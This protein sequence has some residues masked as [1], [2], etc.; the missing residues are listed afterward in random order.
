M[1][2][3]ARRDPQRGLPAATRGRALRATDVAS[4]RLHDTDV[5]VRRDGGVYAR[6]LRWLGRADLRDPSVSRFD[7]SGSGFEARF[8]GTGLTLT[9]G[10][11]EDGLVLLAEVDG[12]ASLLRLDR[13]VRDYLLAGGLAQAEHTLRLTRETEAQMGLTALYGVHVQEG[14]LRDPPAA[15]VRLVEVVGDSVSAGY[16]DLC[17]D[18]DAHFGFDTESHAASYGALAARALGADVS[19]LAISGHGLYRNLDASSDALLPEVYDRA[20]LGQPRPSWRP[21]RS[22]D[23]VVITLGANDLGAAA[24]DPSL[25]MA[26]AYLAFVAA[27]RAHHPGALIVC[28]ANPMELGEASEQARLVG[29][30]GRVVA[31]RRAAGDERVVPLVF[32]LLT[33][34]ELGCD[35]HPSAAAHK[36]MAALLRDLL[37]VK[38]GW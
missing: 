32:P 21:A 19:V 31:A 16:G 28:A 23:A 1:L 30:V 8:V 9:L 26:D 33:R 27:L 2:A 14:A 17:G 20:V 37:R 10:S 29:I 35:Y 24:D 4:A 7:W 12:A 3:W 34:E 5:A 38:L 15:P 13:G 18:A 25:P 36:R 11:E 22:P 6:G